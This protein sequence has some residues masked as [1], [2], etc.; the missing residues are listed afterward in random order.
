MDLGDGSLHGIAVCRSPV[1]VKLYG[2]IA[3][4]RTEVLKCLIV[5]IARVS[6][7]IDES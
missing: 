1:K 5:N 6:Y 7:A 2:R 3:C 4:N